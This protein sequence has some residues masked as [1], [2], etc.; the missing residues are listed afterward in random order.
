MNDVPQYA[1][2]LNELNAAGVHVTPAGGIDIRYVINTFKLGDER[3][4]VMM[5]RSNANIPTYG[6][7]KEIAI[8]S[9]FHFAV[10]SEQRREFPHWVRMGLWLSKARPAG[11]R[12]TAQFTG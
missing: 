9:R 10:L 4:S 2:E 11:C 5:E 12:S 3:T 6:R 8:G 1:Q 7:A